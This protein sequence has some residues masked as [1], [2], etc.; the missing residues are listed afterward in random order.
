[1][2]YPRVCRCRA[3]PR[4]TVGAQ[5]TPA[6][7]RVPHRTAGALRCETPRWAFRRGS[8]SCPR[9]SRHAP[10]LCKSEHPSRCRTTSSWCFRELAPDLGEDDRIEL[11]RW[12]RRRRRFWILRIT[13]AFRVRTARNETRAKHLGSIVAG[14]GAVFGCAAHNRLI[15]TSQRLSTEGAGRV[16]VE[17]A[18]TAGCAWLDCRDYEPL[19]VQRSPCRRRFG[20]RRC[21]ISSVLRPAA[22]RRRRLPAQ[23]VDLFGGLDG[24][25]A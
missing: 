8:N 17:R 19:E 5:P 18:L 22:Y 20:V 10:L 25:E 4:S 3:S 1:M 13:R 7:L 23:A 2:L 14:T 15:A 11:H 12:R 16:V 9:V 6:G 21:G 24:G